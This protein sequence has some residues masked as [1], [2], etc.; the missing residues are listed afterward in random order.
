LTLSVGSANGAVATTPLT[1]TQA[2]KPRVMLVMSNDHALFYKAYSDWNDIT[3]DGVADTTFVP[4]FRYYGYFDPGK[5]YTYTN[6]RFEP[7]AVT[8]DGYCDAVDGDW[9]GN[10]LNWATMSRMDIL[11]KVL[12]GGYRSTDDAT[13]TV[14]ERAF[15]PSDAHSFAKFYNGAD[16]ARLTPFNNASITLCNTTYTD[17]NHQSQNVGNP[18]HADYKAPRLSIAKGDFRYWASNERWQCT[19]STER[20]SNDSGDNTT[21]SNERD[22]VKANDGLGEKD[23][24]VRVKVC[25][26]GLIGT[27]EC[28]GYTDGAN[29]SFKPT[30]LLHDYGEDG[31]ILF[32][33]M[34]GS[35][36]KNKSGGVLRKNISSFADEVTLSNGT[37]S[38]VAGIVKTLN[39]LRIARYEYGDGKGLYNNAD[40]CAWGLSSFAE[41]KCSNWGNPLNEIYTEAIRYITGGSSTAAFNADDTGYISGLTTAAWGNGHLAASEWCAP[42]DVILINSSELSY[43]NDAVSGTDLYGAP[44]PAT[45]TQALGTAEGITNKD[46][47][48]G[49]NGTDNNQICTPKTVSDL[50]LVRGSC[51]GAPRLSGTYLMTGLAHWAHTQDTRDVQG[52]QTITTRAVAL[53]SGVP[54]LV[55]PVPGQNKTVSILP[56]CRN[57]DFNPK[58][59]CAIVDFKILA[60]DLA[61]GTGTAYVNWEDSEQGGDY[62]QDMKGILSY[63][64]NAGANTITITTDVT[65]ESTPFD[66]GFGYVISGTTKDGFHVHSGIEGFTYADP[67]GVTGCNNCQVGDAA[68]SVTYTLGASTAS[69]LQPPLWY[70]AKYGGFTDRNGDRLPDQPNEWDADNDGNPDGYFVASNPGALGGSLARFLDIIATTS[71]SASVVANSLTLQAGT[72]IYQAQFDSTDWSGDL[73]AYPLD[74]SGRPQ[75]A[76]W[77]S[78]T[79]VDGQNW[80]NGRRILTSTTAAGGGV[81]FRWANLAD[82]QKALLKTHPDTGAVQTDAIGQD[83][84]Q[85]LR[86]KTDREVRNGGD[87]RDRNHILGDIVNSEPVFVGAAQR[88]YPDTLVPASPY[89]A[90]VDAHANRSATLFAG[91]NDG[92]LHAFA[93]DTGNERMAYIPRAVYANLPRLTS[94][95]YR[96][97]HRF[98][99]DG[100]PVVGDVYMSTRAAWN[101]VLASGLGAG[102][103]GVFALDITDPN[104]FL[105]ANAGARVLWDYT[106]TDAGFTDLGYTY[107]RPALV[108]TP[109]DNGGKWVTVFGNGF[110]SAAGKAV[111]YVVN[112][113]TGTQLAAVQAQ[114]GPNNGLA[115]VAPVDIDGDFKVDY[116][117]AGDLLGNLWR[118]EPLH[119]GSDQWTVSF[120]G[121]PLFTARDASGAV[122]PITVRPEVMMHPSGGVMVLF[123]TGKYFESGDGVPN[124]ALTNSFYG[125]WD[126]MN[127]T[128]SILRSHLLQQTF[129]AAT[130]ASGYDL[131]VSSQNAATWHVSAGTT[132]PATTPPA[133][134]LGWYLDLLT[135]SGN[136]LVARGELS[137]TN[138]QLRSGRVI[139]TTTTPSAQVCDFGGEGWLVELMAVDGKAPSAAL[140]DLNNDRAFGASDLVTVAMP[141][142]G[143]GS[144]NVA[145]A[146]SAKKSL[147]GI[148]QEPAIVA[149]GGVE[150]KYASGAIRAQIDITGENPDGSAGGRTSWSQV[151]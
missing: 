47:F 39:S 106:D 99:V 59:N 141:L 123:G 12:Y 105:E 53:A 119:D 70:A 37:F 28:K 61:A 56:A 101:T 29:D 136:G 109:D 78:Q 129:L 27:E 87:F 114:A 113:E 90:F 96:A 97:N 146:P 150:Y 86:G 62:D 17:S 148:I 121:L 3:G 74:T 44:N 112:T 131:R 115:S 77:R 16:I 22:P 110:V 48:V 71:S 100:G 143:G 108:R 11:R 75:A 55:I 14:L 21:G 130:T 128:N 9:S 65:A 58:A 24:N 83:R 13:T 45:L 1:V 79:Q 145:L 82:A 46:F 95:S 102:G 72:R 151:R 91:A 81:A 64:V 94:Q 80:N 126:R 116:V 84:L 54:E 26:S 66:M 50:G 63:A 124:T 51:P 25:V 149:A 120:G 10:F 92:M 41:G 5:C 8:A 89:S 104:A 142:P 2:V 117:Y 4:S 43:D 135:P 125:I 127:G 85:Y 132:K 122:Q 20:G 49:E 42:N 107:S 140:F 139:F 133:T 138:P 30:G 73:V 137:V 118:F 6:A 31:R 18:S 98:F 35:Y 23:Y 93:A 134:Q 7:S 57:H 68:T 147:V 144:G 111:L 40:D 60:Q 69:Q 34:T 15:L 19:W 32:G 38:G 76:S 88:L 103:K 36:Q 67:S 33:L 52:V